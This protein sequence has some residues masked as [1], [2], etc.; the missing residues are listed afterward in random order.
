VYVFVRT[1]LSPEQSLVQTA[2][3]C[4]EATSIFKLGELPDHPHLVVLSAK[5]EQRLH[6]VRQYLIDNNIRHA[7]FYESDIGNELTA[8]ATEPLPDSSPLRQLFKKY[9]LLKFN[10]DSKPYIMA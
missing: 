1:D 4:I 10:Q 3:A 7:H 8:I 9:Q 5:N 6:R 2:H